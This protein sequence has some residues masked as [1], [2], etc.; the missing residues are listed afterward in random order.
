LEEGVITTGGPAPEGGSLA[1][2]IS[3][4]LSALQ[5][6][7]DATPQAVQST[8]TP[9]D[10]PVEET[11][12][13]ETPAVEQAAA[14]VV[15]VNPEEKFFADLGK[16]NLSQEAKNVAAASFRRDQQLKALGYS[17]EDIREIRDLGWTKEE[18]VELRQL[19][20]TK[21]DAQRAVAL[22]NSHH[23][24]L[25][26]Y[27]GDPGTFLN[28]LHQTDPVAFRNMVQTL[29]S[30]I[31][32]AD[33]N[34]AFEWW[35]TS[36]RNFLATEAAGTDPDLAEAAKIFLEKKFRQPASPDPVL[37]KREQE[38]AA[39]ERELTERQQRAA[40]EQ[41]QAF[42]AHTRDR[43]VET[44]T[45]GAKAVASEELAG[46]DAVLAQDIT[47][48]A[49]RKTMG[50]LA[51]DKVALE[52]WDRHRRAYGNTQQAQD[53]ILKEVAPKA[54]RIF[55]LHLNNEAKRYG[56]LRTSPKAPAPVVAPQREPIAAA[57]N[58]IKPQP[59]AVNRNDPNYLSKLVMGALGKL[60]GVNP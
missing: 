40:W 46:M 51:S 34:E 42:N 25:Q 6:E 11:P 1:A 28:G 60:G 37:A 8:V 13:A 57:A 15:E 55:R 18:A 44:I 23:Q 36:T 5:A 43:A 12:V 9:T 47:D 53:L 54:D 41:D 2:A 58:P 50:Q 22:A 59:P 45:A 52:A 14:P 17:P 39:R 19:L 20:P 29:Q 24:L 33:N 31:L 16:S 49:L 35:K 56:H 4:R 21:E 27:T 10:P 38:L 32:N 7:Q 3:A 26:D 48:L 30:N